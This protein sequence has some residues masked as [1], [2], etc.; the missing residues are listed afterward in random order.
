MGAKSWQLAPGVNHVGAY[1]VSGKPFASGNID[2]FNKNRAHEVP[3]PYLSRWFQVINKDTT[4][5]V[6]VGFSN[7]GVVDPGTN[8]FTVA[9]ADVD[10][11]GATGDSGRLEIKVASIFISGSTDVDVIAGLTN[12]DTVRVSGS[13]G[14]NWSGSVGVG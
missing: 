7:F 14:P 9:K 1:Q 13:V 12:I 11:N 2:C 5:D 4:N 10:A 8:Y 3:F 6:R